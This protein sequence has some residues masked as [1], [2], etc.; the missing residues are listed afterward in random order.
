MIQSKNGGTSCKRARCTSSVITTGKRCAAASRIT[1]PPTQGVTVVVQHVVQTSA[2]APVFFSFPF[3]SFLL[4]I[5]NNNVVTNQSGAAPNQSFPFPA[6]SSS[7]RLI[8]W[9]GPVPPT[10]LQVGPNR[11]IGISSWSTFSIF[12][13]PTHP[14]RLPVAV[15][16]RF[17]CPCERGERHAAGAAAATRARAATRRQPG[18]PPR[19]RRRGSRLHR[20]CR[21]TTAGRWPCRRP[22]A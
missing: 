1:N 20:R 11:G 18:P 9:P 17:S 12:T 13:H 14:L 15:P 10:H 4:L 8:H 16:F 7:L 5:K 6:L 3:I 21:P 22:T 19:P 2:P